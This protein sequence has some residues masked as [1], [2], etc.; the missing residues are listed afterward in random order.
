MN[1]NLILLPMR[2][3]INAIFLQPD[4]LEGFGYY[5]LE[6]FSNMVANHPEHEFIFIYDRPIVKDL[7]TGPNVRSIKIGPPARHPLS[8]KWWYD[9]SATMALKKTKAAVW[10]QPYGFCSLTTHI[11][12]LLIIHDLAYLQYPQYLPWYHRWYYRFYTKK[13]LLKAK[14]LVTVSAYSK[15]DILANFTQLNEHSISIVPG[16]ART[17]FQPLNWQEKIEVKDGYADGRE[18]FLFVGSIHPRKNLTTLLKAFSLFKKW[19]HSNMKLLIAGKI[20]KQSTPFMQKLNSYKYKNDVVM[21][22]YLPDEV[23][24]KI[25]GAAYALVYPSLLEGFGLPI[26]EAMQCEVPVICSNTSAM[27][28][29]GGN[30]ALYVDPNNPN[31]LAEGLLQLYKNE[32][33]KNSLIQSGIEQAAK[34]NWNQSAKILMN[35][36]LQTK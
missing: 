3:A 33:L 8:F 11:P 13:F 16:A 21:L 32:S 10:V 27:P 14:S 35:V 26:I 15:S 4:K 2:I 18:Y 22:G 28:E 19:Q 17:H 25:T 29:V 30:A 20:G 12:Q 23:L 31:A 6:T 1:G 9:V 24:A 5:V 7:I 36:I 34:F